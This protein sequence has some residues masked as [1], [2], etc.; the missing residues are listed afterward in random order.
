MRETKK[1]ASSNA[2]AGK[3]ARFKEKPMGTTVLRRANTNHENW[4]LFAL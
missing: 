3:G 1:L 2:A 4:Q